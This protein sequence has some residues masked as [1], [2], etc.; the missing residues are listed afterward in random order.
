MAWK[1]LDRRERSPSL[2]RILGVG[3]K[4]GLCRTGFFGNALQTSHEPCLDG[5]RSSWVLTLT[6]PQGQPLISILTTLYFYIKHDLKEEIYLRD[7]SWLCHPEHSLTLRESVH[8]QL[9]DESEECA[10]PRSSGECQMV[11]SGEIWLKIH[12]WEHLTEV[13]GRTI[14]E[15]LDKCK[16]PPHPLSDE[17]WR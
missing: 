13:L 17:L 8:A 14:F 9:P 12:L 10:V 2:S 5:S 15:W 11:A 3:W 7:I 6:W 4:G 16:I 1:W